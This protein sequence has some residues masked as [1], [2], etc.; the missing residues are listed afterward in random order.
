[1]TNFTTLPNKDNSIV[2]KRDNENGEMSVH[3]TFNILSRKEPIEYIIGSIEGM[4]NMYEQC[5]LLQQFSYR[6]LKDVE[7]IFNGKLTAVDDL[8]FLIYFIDNNYI[9]LYEQA[10]EKWPIFIF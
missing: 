5:K 3:A 8:R 4:Y 6:T 1:M 10:K 2:F 7:I 9:E